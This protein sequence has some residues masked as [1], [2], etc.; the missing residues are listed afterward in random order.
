MPARRAPSP[1]CSRQED[2]ANAPPHTALLVGGIALIGAYAILMPILGFLLASLVFMA[3]FMDLGRYR[4]HIA[5]ADH[6]RRRYG[7]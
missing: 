4:N 3:L 5:I 6:Q 2:E 1:S 7:C